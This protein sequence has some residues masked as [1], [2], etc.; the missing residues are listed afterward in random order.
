[1]LFD[2]K[3]VGKLFGFGKAFSFYTMLGFFAG[4]LYLIVFQQG[5]LQKNIWNF[6]IAFAA[7]ILVNAVFPRALKMLL[8]NSLSDGMLEGS[9]EFAERVSVAVS[10]VTLTLTYFFGVGLVFVLSRLA[11][12]RFMEIK[13][14]KK[15]SYW[16]DKKE[17]GKIEEMF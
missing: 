16:I 9:K 6:A 7:V 3:P 1:M 12:K 10:W 8:K 2:E 5:F 15:P 14:K 11:G 4:V 13:A 17:S